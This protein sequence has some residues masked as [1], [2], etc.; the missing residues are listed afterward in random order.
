MKT[1]RRRLFMKLAIWLVPPLYKAY[2]AFVYWT[3]RTEQ[4][5]MERF[6]AGAD[7]GGT[8]LRSTG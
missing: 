2:M 7:A 4:K 1:V 8:S 3:S 5:G 6:F